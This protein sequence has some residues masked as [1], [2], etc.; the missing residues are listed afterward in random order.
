MTNDEQAVRIVVDTNVVLSGLLFPGSVP[1]RA[2]LRAQAGTMLAS[3]ATCEEL[4]E[5]MSRSRFDRYVD[6]EIRL[7]LVREYQRTCVMVEI[8]SPIHAC[9]DPRDDK[10]L[11]VAIYGKA[12]VLLTG[13][14]DL[15]ALHPFRSVE[16]LSPAAFLG[17]K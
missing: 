17:D 4:A 15:L 16:I 3:T 13:D 1:S 5:T 6:T 12:D 9:R 2:L 8:P 10:F 14:A 11:E 7:Q